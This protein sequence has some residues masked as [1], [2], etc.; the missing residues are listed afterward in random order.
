MNQRNDLDLKKYNIEIT[1][2]ILMISL[3]PINAGVYSTEAN[4]VASDIEQDSI[5][6]LAIIWDSTRDEQFDEDIPLIW[7]FFYKIFSK[8]I[9]AL[10]SW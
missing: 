5:P 1:S 8:M 10:Q 7:R 2:M 4:D 3:G 9:A 6:F